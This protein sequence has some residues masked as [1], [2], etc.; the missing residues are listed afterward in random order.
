MHEG[1][2]GLEA[3][4]HPGLGGRKRGAGRPTRNLSAGAEA[5]RVPG[6][7]EEDAEG[8]PGL[9]LVLGGAKLEDGRLGGVQVVDVDVEVHLLGDVLAGPLR[10]VEALDPLEADA[11]AIVGAD[12]AHVRLVLHDR[13][14]EQ[15]AVE[16]REALGVGA[17]EDDD[18]DTSDRHG[19]PV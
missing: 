1:W 19:Q 10:R 3:V 13:P 7:V 15:G 5:E 17:V 12:E 14:V 18:G 6:G 16:L 9:V 2:S 4:G 11:V 8:C